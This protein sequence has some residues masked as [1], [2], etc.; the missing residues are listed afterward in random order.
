VSD[1]VFVA[2]QPILDRQRQTFAY[3]LLFR[4]SSRAEVASASDDA[5]T[6]D[7]IVNS[8]LSIGLDALT[9]GKRAFINVTRGLLLAGIPWVLPPSR[10]VVELLE[11]IEADPEVMAA[12]RELRRAG[13]SIALDDFVLTERNA[14]LVELADFVKIDLLQASSPAATAYIADLARN[15]R[16]AL[17]AEKV[18]TVEAFDRA[19]GDGYSY[20]Q[21]FFFGRPK[22]Q[23]GRAVRA[24]QMAYIRL[25][26]ELSAPDITLSK[27]AEL[28][29]HDTSLCVRVL[30]TVNSAG[31]GLRAPIESIR[32]ALVLLGCDT[33]RRW[34]SVLALAGLGGRDQTELIVLSTVRARFCEFLGGRAGGSALAAEGFLLGMCSTLDALLERPME[35]ILAQLPLGAETRAALLGERNSRREIIDCAIA[36]ER[37]EWDRCVELATRLGV[38]QKFLPVDYVDALGW[39]RELTKGT[40]SPSASSDDSVTSS[41]ARA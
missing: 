3:E 25:V 21:G 24:N 13:Y 35:A 36:Y 33:V 20:F 9:D 16:P 10:V 29:K 39:A 26:R 11:N 30:Q 40:P 5:A 17:L 14:P 38:D 28:I 22:M 4:S 34:A 37:G 2:R 23:H 18:E 12:C 41:A 15:G 8:V 1:Y 7:V 19:M 32:D 27:L 31:F 6:A